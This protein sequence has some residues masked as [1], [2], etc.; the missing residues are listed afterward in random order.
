MSAALGGAMRGSASAAAELDI[1]RQYELIV[2]QPALT[3]PQLEKAYEVV[4][5]HSHRQYCE[6]V[7]GLEEDAQDFLREQTEHLDEPPPIIAV[8]DW[9]AQGA[10][11][12]TVTAKFEKSPELSAGLL[13]G[14]MM[15]GK[16]TAGK[17][18]AGKLAAPF[19]MKAAPALAAVVAGPGGVVFGVLVDYLINSGVALIQR[20]KFESDVEA[21]LT[22]TEQ[23]W[24]AQL[25]K[26]L[27]ET[28]SIWM[29]DTREVVSRGHAR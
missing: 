19:A 21:C 12:T 14:G 9:K 1:E 10:L 7:A 8:W 28:V 22:A 13:L 17:V 20:P 2:L 18:L 27:L 4:L 23:Q 5:A 26:A 6:M 24:C 15:V 25:E 11:A 29:A 3:Q 16:A